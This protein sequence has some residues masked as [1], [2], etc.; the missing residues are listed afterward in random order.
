MS[1]RNKTYV[2]F[3]ADNDIHYYRLMQA[4]KSNNH[5]DFNFHNA[6]DYNNI[7]SWSNEDTIKRRLRERMNESKIFTLLVGERTKF[8]YKYVRW[9]IELALKQDLPIIVVNLNGRK[10]MDSNRCPA[11]IRDEL[12]IHIAFGSKIVQYALTNWPDSHQQYRRQ[13]ETGS[14]SYKNHVYDQLGVPV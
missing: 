12:A 9:E 5:F 3:D 2:A 6:H 7:M 4:W 13:G 8:L 1:Y 10:S 11:I 14:Y